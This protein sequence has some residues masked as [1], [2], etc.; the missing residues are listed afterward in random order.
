M[1]LHPPEGSGKGTHSPLMSSF[2]VL[3][4][5]IQGEVDIGNWS[6]VKTS[7]TEPSFTHLFF[8]NDLV[9]FA[10]VTSKNC[11]AINKVLGDFCK[12]SSQKVNLNKSSIF[13]SPHSNPNQAALL[14]RE[15]GFKISKTF[16]K[17]LGVPI[18]VNGRNKRAYDFLI[19]NIRNKLSGWKARTF[20]LAGH[21]TLINAVTT[22]IPTHVWQC[23]MLPSHISKEMDKLNRNFLW[24]NIMGQK[25]IHLLNWDII[26]QPKN[27]GGLGIKKS[28]CRNVALLAK[29]TWT[30]QL[31]SN[32]IWTD[33]FKHKYNSSGS[34]NQC[35]SIIYKSF[36]L[37]NTV[38]DKGRGFL[39]GNGHSINF[40]HD[41]WLGSSTLRE[42][43]LGPFNLREDTLNLCDL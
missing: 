4:W 35:K 7:R 8:T 40:W 21:C 34:A 11:Q 10:K 22:A 37:A 36:C 28:K 25:K 30:L 14:E 12:I 26:S 6:S 13:I 5:L 41:N 15:L 38:C 16:G 2:F 33:L 9:L 29:R 3:A 19:E 24:G 31:G 18:L 1:N 32:E 23:C 39:I 20:S 43:I 17:Y 27:V 42:K